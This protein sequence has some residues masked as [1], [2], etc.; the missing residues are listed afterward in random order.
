MKKSIG[1]FLGTLATAT[2]LAGCNNN[3]NN[4]VTPTPG[5]GCANPPYQMEILYPKPGATR[6]S[7]SSAVIYVSTTTPLPS[8]NQYDFQLSQSNGNVQF[9][10]GPGGQP[11]SGPGSGFYG[12]SAA[13]IPSPHNNPTYANPVYYATNFVPIGPLQSAALMWNDAGTGCT[14]N[15]TVSTFAT[16]S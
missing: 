4:V 6:V 8:G 13:Q 5:P 14:P 10:T 16:G 3:G 7:P 11:L 1:V 9:T 15:V 12:V 2:L